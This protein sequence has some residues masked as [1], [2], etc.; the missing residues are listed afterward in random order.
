MSNTQ[1]FKFLM[2]KNNIFK[3]IINNSKWKCFLIDFKNNKD[4]K[5]RFKIKIENYYLKLIE[6]LIN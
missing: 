5:T 3:I 2:L 1:N 4:K 6:K